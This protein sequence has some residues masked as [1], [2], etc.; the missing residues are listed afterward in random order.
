MAVIFEEKKN[1]F[2]L[3]TRNTQYVFKIIGGKYLIHCYYGYRSESLDFAQNVL[4]L[5]FS[6][7]IKVAEQDRFSLNDAPLECSFHG[8]G[9]YRC[10]SLKIKGK[11][12]DSCTFF[13]Y[14]D[15]E[16]I[17]GRKEIPGIPFARAAEDTET[18]KIRMLDEVNGCYLTLYYTVYPSHDLITR[19]FTIDNQG[20]DPVKLQKAMSICLDLPG[21]E[22]DVITLYGCQTAE[23]NMQRKS[24]GYGNYSIG[25]RRGASSHDFNPFLAL[26]SPDTN[27][28]SG[29]VY[30]FNLVYSGSFLDEVEVDAQ[31]NTRV[32]IGLGEENFA[33]TIEA[34]EQFASPEAIMLYTSQG[35]GDMS[36]KLHSFIRDTIVPEEIFKQRPVVLN[37]WEA[38]YFDIDSKT[39][40][41]LAEE[42]KAC[43]MDMIVV[44]DGWFGK[45]N[46]DTAG[47]GDWYPNPQKFPEG[48]KQTVEE[49]KKKG[50]KFGIWIEPEMVNPDSELYRAHPDWC[51]NCRE[52][53][54]TLA[55]N[56]LLLDF[57]NPK[58]LDFLKESF[59]ETFRNVP[60]DY[61]KWDFNRTL[62]EVGS[63]Y[64]PE[65]K[66]DEAYFRYQ[67]GV[68]ELY[69]WFR[70]NFPQ[71]M[72]ENCS[73]GGG[74]YDLGMMA[75][76]HQIWA[77]D[78]TDAADRLRIQYGSTIA[79]PASVMSCHVSKPGE[80]RGRK[81]TLDYKFK[82]ALG[83]MLGYELNLL[84]ASDDTKKEIKDQIDF[85]RRV[86]PVIKNGQ[87][88]RLVS[89][90]ERQEEVSAYYYA[91]KPEGAERI[92]LSY[93]QNEPYQRREMSW[94]MELPPLKVYTLRIRAAAAE[95]IYQEKITGQMYAGIDLQRGIQIRMAKE[96]EYGKI[97]FLEKQ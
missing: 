33:Y 13:T 41:E 12:G 15:Y 32:G 4:A 89:P 64:L 20:Q 28:E 55:R 26:A 97:M 95:A 9:D 57:C 2:L 23:R 18:L 52:R 77:S 87:L 80:R 76:S 16:I 44:D 42:A 43:G 11:Y 78:N 14:C 72:I 71:V 37:T 8:S 3:T 74:R 70:E 63:A 10:S 90:Y 84:E 86:E 7:G 39:V 27:E 45:R 92:L 51:L 34:G 93:L 62:S 25:S 81:N 46:D 68:Y 53:T 19:Y 96:A 91:D 22:Y 61:L 29:D 66:Q 40:L 54:P 75:V 21:H 17:K 38:L 1:M 30:A 47:L 82:V 79:Y 65:D 35:L 94:H 59:S 50:M 60:I 49:V 36:R 85:Y 31:G 73:G 83:G 58:V 48:L 67:L 24:V 69:Y 88:F 56:Q 5:P 6:P